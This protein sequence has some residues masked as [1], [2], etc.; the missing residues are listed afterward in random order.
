[1][2]VIFESFPIRLFPP[3][4]Q[5][6]K[7]KLQVSS[8][9]AVSGASL[10]PLLPKPPDVGF[11]GRDET[12]LE[13]DR[14]FDT[15]SV[16]LLHAFAGSGKTSV[17]AEFARWYALT[18]GVDGPVLFTSSE[19]HRPARL[20]HSGPREVPLGR[21]VPRRSTDRAFLDRAMKTKRAAA[22]SRHPRRPRTL[23]DNETVGL[24]VVEFSLN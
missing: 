3:K 21:D 12:L 14:S 1:M 10:D 20:S 22:N 7:L 8:S 11:F 16:V 17:A 13:L 4:E 15:Q 5:R 6:P 23:S 19:T 2:P 24:R 9:R 18:G